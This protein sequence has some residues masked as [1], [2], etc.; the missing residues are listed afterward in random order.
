MWMITCFFDFMSIKKSLLALTTGVALAL[1][2][3]GCSLSQSSYSPLENEVYK[4]CNSFSRKIPKGF[5]NKGECYHDSSLTIE[6]CESGFGSDEGKGRLVSRSKESDEEFSSL[7]V[8]AY[9]DSKEFIDSDEFPFDP[10]H[11]KNNII[12][13]R[14][15]VGY[16]QLIKK[17]EKEELTEEEKEYLQEVR[18][19]VPYNRLFV[20]AKGNKCVAYMEK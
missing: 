2:A 1:G 18:E 17:A 3:T 14:V 10:N 13:T 6:D 12:F 15:N 7:L 4:Y 16:E 19:N 5:V 9:I 11:L 20:L 8:A